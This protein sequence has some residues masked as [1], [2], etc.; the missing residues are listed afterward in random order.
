MHVTRQGSNWHHANLMHWKPLLI[1]QALSQIEKTRWTLIEYNLSAELNLGFMENKCSFETGEMLWIQL[2]CA[3][4]DWNTKVNFEQT[5]Y[6]S[7]VC[8]VCIPPEYRQWPSYSTVHDWYG[9][10]TIVLQIIFSEV[11]I[12][13]IKFWQLEPL[14]A[15][16]RMVYGSFQKRA[17]YR[18]IPICQP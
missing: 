16:T 8:S 7:A 14:V 2:W 17:S 1:I 5:D 6:L 13:E 18:P 15:N 11:A 12:K 10:P 3:A 4:C 9:V